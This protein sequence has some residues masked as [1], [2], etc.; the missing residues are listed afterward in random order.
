MNPIRQLIAALAVAACAAPPL[1]AEPAQVYVTVCT[2]GAGAA[3]TLSRTAVDTAKP[4][5]T[6]KAPSRA[7]YIFTHWTL[8]TAQ[9]FAPR[10]A[11]G[12]SYDALTFTPYEHTTA[13]A[14]YVSSILDSDSDGM[15]DGHELYWYGSLETATASSDTDC[16]G[17][18]FAEEVQYATN[19]LYAD[20]HYNAVRHDDSEV[21]DY[22]PD[23]I[24]LLTIRCD[25]DGEFFPTIREYTIAGTLVTTPVGSVT[26]STFAYWTT[27][28]VPVRDAWGRAIDSFTFS[29]PTHNLDVVAV[30]E[31]RSIKRNLLYWYGDETVSL[32]SDTDGD[33]FTLRDEL[34]AGNNPLFADATFSAFRG[35]VHDSAAPVQYNAD[36]VP[37]LTIRS[38]PEGELFPS[39]SEYMPVG[40]MVTSPTLS[41]GTSTFAYWT[42]NGVRVVDAW[43]RS[44]DTAK[45]PMPACDIDL[46][47]ITERNEAKRRYMYWTGSPAPDVD[48]DV[49][50]DGYSLA[51]ELAQGTNPYFPDVRFAGFKGVVHGDTS[52]EEMNLQVYEDVTGILVGG[53]FTAFFASP[54]DGIEGERFGEHATPLTLDWNGDGKTDLFVGYA[55]GA[56]LFLNEGTNANP[57][58]TE[59]TETLPETLVE[60]FR[61]MTRPALAACA[62]RP[63]YLYVSDQGGDI[64]KYDLATGEITET[65]LNGYPGVFDKS[66]WSANQ[67]SGAIG[68]LHRW[69][70]NGEI[71]GDATGIE[72]TSRYAECDSEGGQFATFR[73]VVTADG[74][75]VTLAGGPRGTSYIDLGANILPNDNTAFTIEIWA[76]MRSVQNWSRII[77]IGSGT[78]NCMMWA[79]T[80]GTSSTSVFGIQGAN[81][82]NSGLTSGTVGV[83]YLFSIVF[84]PQEDGSWQVTCRRCDTATGE[85][86]SSLVYST[87]GTEWRPSKLGQTNCWLGHSQWGGDNDA[88]A[89]YNE[90]R[91][92]ARALTESELAEHAVAG[93][94]QNF[95]PEAESVERQ[96]TLVALD[97][98]GRLTA[99]DG[100]EF[101]VDEALADGATSLSFGNADHDGL[102]DILAGDASGRIWYYKRTGETSF[103]LQNK[104]WGGTFE[105]FARD[106][107]V[108]AVDWDDDGDLDALAGTADGRL[109]LLR[110][111]N[112]GRPSNLMLAAGVDS[113]S[114]KWDPLSQ[115]RIRGYYVY[116]SAHGANAWRK[117][118]AATIPRYMD[119]TG[120]ET[121]TYDYAVTSVS[122]LYK[123]GNS[124]PITVE[125]ERTEPASAAVG[126]VGF[127][128]QP[129]AGFAGDEV[130]VDFSVE[131]SINLSAANMQLKISFDPDVLLPTGVTKSGLTEDME[132]VETRGPGT[133]IV[134]GGGGTVKPGSGVFL[135]FNFAVADGT[136]LADTSVTIEEFEL[137]SVGNRSVVPEVLRRTDSV[138][139]GGDSP[140]PS[141]PARVVPGSRGDLD[142]D[143]RLGWNDVELF[144]RWKDSATDEVPDGIRSAGDFN[145]DGAM[146]NRDYILLKRF[147]RER[148]RWG[149]NMEGWNDN[150]TSFREVL[151]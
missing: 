19:P 60:L 145:G 35:V 102:T 41:I 111:P 18:S 133:W 148:E 22:N 146:D 110:D 43:G 150:H 10:D 131:N 37:M 117:L 33:G 32:D 39:T 139:L 80:Q 28:G 97:R 49:D 134:A 67:Q 135:T 129:S 6:E 86:L 7:G 103:T 125:S 52:V 68:L 50:G 27:N 132:I 75:Q 63:P 1:F 65:G 105:G 34:A 14:H 89:S 53:N 124:R 12:R 118:D 83:E 77:D 46:V 81:G 16:D 55:G 130:S 95:N 151:K 115:S 11:W 51:E 144:L 74:S 45:F 136:R 121:A 61:S 47:A 108:N 91:V 84:E 96:E 137:K 5:T 127:T 15:P 94:D 30:T 88:N 36:G 93:P 116:R 109:Y 87:A 112:G 17:L 4:F 23:G 38:L 147:F 54:I 104:V 48:A 9:T 66:D 40:R 13:T 141:D 24:A 42:T 106:L 2:E 126:T 78:G 100:T 123:T 76:T 140:D 71:A 113:V 79:W 149:G 138:A 59:A 20:V 122:R 107:A 99:E 128:W 101:S 119:K 92:W 70:F 73:G 25:P 64:C 85:V 3:E 72:I 29:M 26:K 143:G 58:L 114:L 21:L 120:P 56:R 98:Y 57:D 142:G 90:M 62:A 31:R 69:S 44:V 8:S 82:D